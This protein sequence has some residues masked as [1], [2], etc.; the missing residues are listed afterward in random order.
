MQLT[1]GRGR[2]GF[3]HRLAKKYSEMITS[4]GDKCCGKAKCG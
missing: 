3:V 4:G 2:E 1:W